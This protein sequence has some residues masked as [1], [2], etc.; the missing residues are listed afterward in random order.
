MTSSLDEFIQLDRTF[1]ELALEKGAGDDVDLTRLLGQRDALRWPSLLNEY[2]VIL[3]SEAG[4]GKTEE[5]RNIARTLRQEGKSAFFVRI[6]HVSQDFEDAFEEGSFEEFRAWAAS[7]EEGWLLLDSVDEARL[8]DPKDFERAIRKL[9]RLLAPVLQQAHIVI[10]GRTTAWRAKTDLLLCRTALPYRH[11]EKTADEDTSADETLDIVTKKTDTRPNPA[12][13]FRIVAL[14]DL[15]GAQIDAFLRGKKV[16]DPKAFRD[17]VDRKEAWSLTTRPQDLAELV[18]FWNDHQRIG[19]RL[20]LMQSSIARRLEERDQNRSEARPIAIEKLRLGVRLVAA[21][22]TLA[23]E[24]AI[25][26]PDGA[27]NAKG[28]AIR[29]VLTDW[30]DIDCATLLSRPIFD[31]GIYGTVRF[32]HR[33]VREYLTAEWLHALIVDEGSRA[34]I[35][36]LFFRSQY[37]IEVIVPTMRS[38]LPWLAIL[39]ERI[40]ARVCRL[41]PEV[42]FEGGDPSQL[43]LETRRNILRQACEQLAQPAYG[44]SLTD[45]AA[46][47]RFA[48]VDLSDEIKALL[49][50]Y[51]ED[52]DIAWF[53]L[54][55]VWQGEIAGAAAEAKSFALTSRAKY[56]RIAAFRALAAVGSAAD[57]A[58]VHRAFLDEDGEL[59]RHWLAE[60]IPGLPKDGEAVTWL[61]EALARTPA[62][63]QYEVDDLLGALS[64]LIAD[65][66]LPVPPRLITGFH[67]LLETPPVIERRHCEISKRYSWL[68]QAAAQSVL[69]LIEAR[70]PSALER[71]SLSI[72]RKLPLAEAHG[73]HE[74][75]DIKG[76]LSKHIGEWRELNYALFWQDAVETRVGQDV[77]KGERLTHY[78]QVGTFG[79]FWRFGA[80]SFDPICQ[81]IASRTLLDDRLVALT[82]AFAIY[83]ENGRPAIWRR[84]L[85][86]LASSEPELKSALDGLFRPQTKDL[87]RWRQQE[88]RWKKRAAREAARQEANK[89][90]WKE[91][92]DANVKALRD[93]GKPGVVTNAQYYLHDRMRDAAER[94][95]KWSDGRWR[96]LIPEFGEPI[97]RAFRDGAVRFW[98][99]HRPQLL[100]E[101]AQA[102]TTPFSVIFGL[103]GLAIEAREADGWP[104]GLLK[105]E[106]EVATRYALRELNGFPSWLPSLYVVYPETVIDLVINEIDHELATEDP[107]RESHY[108]LYDASWSGDWMWDRLAPL[109]LARLRKPPKSIGNLRYMLNIVQGSSLDDSTIAKLAAQ[110]AKAT[111]NLA[112]APMWFAMWAGVDPAVAIPAL[113]ARLAEIEE[114]GNK[115]L[116]AMRFITALV[117][118]RRESRSARQ[119]Y[120]TVE[121]MKT[122]YLLMHDY[123]RK[124]DDIDRA[125]TGVFSPGLRDDAQDARNALFS[126]IRETPGKEAFL[127][128]TEMSR[129]H[130][131]ETDRP[132]LAFHAKEKAAL[133]ADLSAWSPRQ[134]R[135]FHDRLERTPANHRDLWYLAV[136]RLLDLKHDLEEGDASIA[137]IL[138]PVDREVEIRKYIGNWCRERSGGRYVIPQEEE[139][140]DAKRPDLRF[141]GVGFDGPVPAE[142]KLA[143][144]WTGPHLFERLEIQ[145]CGDYLRDRR[146]SRGIFGLV[147]HGTKPSWD[148]PNGKRAE[149]FDALIEALQDHW[150]IL[151]PQFPAVEDIRVIGIDLTK[152]GVDAKTASTRKTAKK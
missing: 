104:K 78:W 114:D 63:E 61:L 74:F 4:S 8:R 11:A 100:S 93:P 94:S 77:S 60:L 138:K 68:T 37:G 91:Y 128:L 103:A 59:N 65:W 86:H 102:N 109:V 26:V 15:H 82:L 85:R 87:Q 146:S 141:H 98:R 70:D 67:T 16:H 142:L 2:R 116:F 7:G 73:E 47:Q 5:I 50:Q 152:R 106:V 145:L 124:K 36:S 19:S 137:S 147:Y 40:L 122:L 84:R 126:F 14:D 81:D 54:R 18:E 71:A 83:R 143:D 121:H 135:D 9:G 136:D 115:T 75:R 134:V 150:A 58:E 66:P 23:Q 28:I 55:M 105:A 31:E 56:T 92:L 79:H 27:N 133:E 119:A 140:A 117:G 129:I 123:V 62:K 151:A 132:W 76:D 35:E 30:D 1:H 43:P 33:S 139:L 3:L 34:R 64:Q 149:S 80:D 127:A 22:T 52:D 88:A 29:E 38:V 69:R 45:Y 24:S 44:R 57:Q 131:A 21:A 95:D 99:D 113:A 51:G 120:R 17:G 25:R 148:L 125:G 108:V 101:G 89:R 48:N 10:T 110:K 96:S 118:G 41:A 20:E 111:K 72:L 90:E 6:E 53:L 49:A 112:A 46:V 39:D 144:K 97:A 42:V 130:P 107:E 12:A 13:P 32:H